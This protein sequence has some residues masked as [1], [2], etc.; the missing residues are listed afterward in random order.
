MLKK[1]IN[2]FSP[3]IS[4]LCLLIPCQAVF[5]QIVRDSTLPTNSTVTQNGNLNIITGGTELGRNLFH[6]FK[7]FSVPSGNEVYFNNASNIQNVISR[8][9]GTSVSNIDGLLRANGTV[10]FI[11][12][13]PNGIFLGQN[14]RLD[15][16]GSILLT[17]A[18]SIKFS[19][20][21][22]GVNNPEQ[23]TLL[24]VNIPS[25]LVFSNPGTIQMQGAGAQ[26]GN[27]DKFYLPTNIDNN[28]SIISAGTG[29]TI[30]LI[31]GNIYLNGSTIKANEGDVEL[32]SV[33]SGNVGIISTADGW[34]FNYQGVE[35]FQNINLSNH[36][37]V[38]SSGSGNIHL[39]GHNVLLANGSVILIQNSGSSSSGNIT[40]NAS[41][42][43]DFI[44]N[45]A[46]ETSP[47]ILRTEALG[48]GRGGDIFIFVENLTVEQGGGINTESFTSA[49]GGDVIVY[50]SDSVDLLGASTRNQVYRS[51]ISANTFGSGNAGNI[52]LTT[53]SLNAKDGALV[54]STTVGSGDAGS[55]TVQ[56]NS[57]KLSGIDISAPTVIG[58]T[59][60][61]EG[62][63]G[64]VTINAESIQLQQGAQINTSTVASGNAGQVT[65][66]AQRVDVSGYDPKSGKNSNISSSAI[67]ASSRTQQLFGSPSI[68]TGNSGDV[69]INTLNLNISNHGSI[70][71]L[72]EGLGD[73]GKLQI[74]A[75]FIN[76]TDQGAIKADTASGQGGNIGINSQD[77]RLNNATIT[78]SARGDKNGGNISIATKTLVALESSSIISNAV[79][80]NGGNIDI[81]A[82]GV[83]ISPDSQ[84][85]STSVLGVNGT[86]TIITPGFDLS[87][88]VISSNKFK[89]PDLSSDCRAK[90]GRN[91]LTN[92]GSGGLPP[93]PTDAL[94]LV[95]EPQNVA[96]SAV[97]INSNKFVEAQGWRLN[98]DKTLSLVV[99]PET[100]S[101]VSSSPLNPSLC[102]YSQAS[103]F[104][105]P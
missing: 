84:I 14:A 15:I 22:F 88:S 31:G 46:N 100:D 69:T 24:S 49:R 7:E 66:D 81:N 3:S 96:S 76:L 67:A 18:D 63:A 29:K 94:N 101:I 61:K 85:S 19:D 2:L 12:L 79:K 1:M 5:A 32:G 99:Q 41:G 91:Q 4:A 17:T 89:N 37:L 68:P 83:F 80:G 95:P 50:A 58:S 23:E 9:T 57:I 43:L 35:D 56:A 105:L 97:I 75:P 77:L 102:E 51:D 11:L 74:N 55:V 8:V 16:K 44:A 13:N 45:S 54:Q 52:N 87:R 48:E 104:Y 70:N 93:G 62:N 38:A 21:I 90:D 64:Q 78:A 26:I 28:E 59:T 39:Q 10:N 33:G 53:N 86:V 65:I 72:N 103:S 27:T 20:G 98:A 82:I 42:F 73:A 60:F 30:A 6:S 34:D 36:A 47:N 92:A 71:V 25:Q 40:V